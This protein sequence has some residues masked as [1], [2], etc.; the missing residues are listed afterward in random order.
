MN[1]I[2]EIDGTVVKLFNGKS[3]DLIE[4]FNIDP[5]DL[6]EDF[7]SQAA[8]Y[9]YFSVLQAEAE[10]ELAIS[11]FNVDQEYAISD[12]Y[13][14]HYKDKREEKYTEAVIKSLVIRDDSYINSRRTQI[15]LEYEV[16]LLK[17]LTKALAQRADMLIS[18]GAMTRQ[19]LSMTG[20]AIKERYDDVPKEVKTILAQRNKSDQ[21]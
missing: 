15:Q 19:E 9:A 7:S 8:L 21:V 16:S 5:D 12:E 1:I 13:W 18:L 17:A 2:N 3:I 4:I 10:R 6:S 20:M 14:R 11:E